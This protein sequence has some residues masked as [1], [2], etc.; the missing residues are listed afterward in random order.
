MY[1]N[2]NAKAFLVERFFCPA[3]KLDNIGNIGN[4]HGVKARPTPTTKNI[5]KLVINPW[6]ANCSVKV[7]SFLGALLVGSLVSLNAVNA[8]AEV[9]LCIAS[10]AFCSC[11]PAILFSGILITSGG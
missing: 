11:S 2:D 9:A 3:I 1:T 5:S 8:F 6:L 4:T 7:R 10:S